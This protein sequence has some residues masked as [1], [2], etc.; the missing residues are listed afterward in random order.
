MT[1]LL[2]LVPLVAL[3]CT[4]ADHARDPGESKSDE[5]SMNN[6]IASDLDV[7]RAARVFFNHQ[8][9]GFNLLEG[10]QRLSADAGRELTIVALDQAGAGARAA[11][12]GWWHTTGGHNGDPRSKIDFFVATMKKPDFKPDLAFMKFC[13]VDFNPQTDV[14]A[15]FDYY[16]RALTALERERP[17]VRFA[18][19]TV[20]LMEKPSDFKSRLQRVLG[21]DV[22]GDTANIKRAEFNER[23]ARAFSSDPIFDLARGESTR[24]DGTRE[25]FEKHGKVYYSLETSYTSDGGH[26]NDVGQRVLG[27][28]MVRFVARALKP[29]LGASEH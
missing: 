27:A 11:G 19:V 22:W 23:L 17:D 16:Q 8:S 14:A 25:S 13:Y 10:V 9:V 5:N 12:P 15:V 4:R 7:A 20:P 3:G 21:R 1:P 24:P 6:D 29:A 28:E 2:A 18:H 26:L